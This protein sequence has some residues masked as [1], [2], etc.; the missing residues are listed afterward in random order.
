MRE[1]LYQVE[2]IDST[3]PVG[4]PF[5]ETT[6]DDKTYAHAIPGHEFSVR[7]TV[8]R[9]PLTNTF[10]FEYLRVGLFIDG[11]DVNYWKRMDLT[12]APGQKMVSASFQG[13]KKNT[14]DLRAFQFSTPVL[15]SADEEA[16]PQFKA[17]LS[18]K[19]LGQIKIVVHEAVLAPGVFENKSG[20]HE[21]PGA[22]KVSENKKFWQ[23]ASVTTT[24]GRQIDSEREKFTPLPVWKNISAIPNYEMSLSYHTAEMVSFIQTFSEHQKRASASCNTAATKSTSNGGNKSSSSSAG[25][26]GKRRKQGTAA[27]NEPIMVDLTQDD[28]EEDAS[29]A[30]SNHRKRTADKKTNGNDNDDDIF[31]TSD[32]DEDEVNQEQDSDVEELDKRTMQ[33]EVDLLDMTSEGDHSSEWQKVKRSRA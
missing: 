31:D 13:W 21:M 23:Q 29:V 28:D 11:H 6:V 17:V 7:I 15:A 10:P 16:D 22:Q 24:A 33:K 5:P 4:R 32:E 30:V 9:N 2:L 20:F 19:P 8:H 25:G 26:G 3:Q 27:A 1:G 18:K 14:S 12:A